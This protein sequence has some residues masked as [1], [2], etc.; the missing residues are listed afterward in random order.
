MKLFINILCMHE[1][2]KKG[3]PVTYSLRK[4]AIVKRWSEARITLHKIDKYILLHSMS[5]FWL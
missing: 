3:C 4:M 2:A 5:N 1:A